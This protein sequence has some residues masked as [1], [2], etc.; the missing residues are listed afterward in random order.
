SSAARAAARILAQ[1]VFTS[2]EILAG[3][4]APS[5][6]IRPEPS[7]I[8]AR[9]PVPPPSM[10][11]KYDMAT[12]FERM[13]PKQYQKGRVNF[14]TAGKRQFLISYADE[15]LQVVLFWHYR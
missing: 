10:P 2:V 15:S 11:R 8:A 12:P 6:I 9:Q 7:A 1:A 13:I 3:P 5:P 14:K 4:D